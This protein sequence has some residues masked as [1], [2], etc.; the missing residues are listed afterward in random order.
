MKTLARLLAASAAA[1]LLAVTPLGATIL[2]QMNLEELAGNSGRIFS[3]TV[4]EVD[5]G[6]L[7]VG[8]GKVPTVTY[9]VV[10]DAAFRGEFVEKDG[11]RIVDLRM[12]GDAGP[13]HAGK[14]VGFTVLP[15]MPRIERG[16][17]YLF[18]TTVPS[19][20]GLS[21]TVG[22]GQGCFRITGSPGQEQLANEFDNLGLFR[23]MS[24]PGVPERG[25]IPYSTLAGRLQALLSGK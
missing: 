7:E 1:V 6:I 4:I 10:V 11:H 18:F 17:R 13:R 12:V 24:A 25:P 20:V 8:G 15:E 9:R 21:T 14:A 3:G 2:K 22:L 23:G 16:Q 5:K 19:K